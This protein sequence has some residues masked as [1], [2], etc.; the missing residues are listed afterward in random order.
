MP[1]RNTSRARRGFGIILGGLRD[2]AGET[3]A[4]FAKRLYI[5]RTTVANVETGTPPS[6]ALVATLAGAFREHAVEIEAAATRFRKPRSASL[7]LSAQDQAF[8][9]QIETLITTNDLEEAKRYLD[10]HTGPGDDFDGDMDQEIWLLEQLSI[11]ETLLGHND[12]SRAAL[13]Q[14]INLADD[15]I[16]ADIDATRTALRLRLTVSFDRD[17]HT[18]EAHRLLDAALGI[19]PATP[20]LWYRKAML[21][22][23]QGDLGSTLAALELALRHRGRRQDILYIRGQIFTEWG[24]SDEA[25]ADLKEVSED[26]RRPEHHEACIV[27]A[28]AYSMY[29]RDEDIPNWDTSKSLELRKTVK[30]TLLGMAVHVP[31]SPW[32]HY[33]RALCV[34]KEYETASHF[35]DQVEQAA[36]IDVES[37]SSLSESITNLGTL[38]RDE[39]N[40]A[41]GCGDG[42]LTEYHLRKI[43]DIRSSVKADSD[44]R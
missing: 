33:F 27:C 21:H 18:D 34:L 13:E 7:K 28:Y 43:E 44:R 39:L 4:D 14:A 35:R 19:A 41:L 10:A 37:I 30:Q 40:K 2:T 23:H 17:N 1:A 42:E 26:H 20:D 11:V 9:H 16:S 31:N 22:W 32:P 15:Y 24:R 8:R 6:P 38:I 36:F 12:A 3:Q 29:R 5:A 25:I